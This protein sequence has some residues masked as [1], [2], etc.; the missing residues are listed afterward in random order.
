ML[1]GSNSSF[2]MP[3]TFLLIGIPGLEDGTLW[4]SISFCAIYIVAIVGNCIILYVIKTE[5]S[6]HG[7]M[8]FFLSMLA[9][10]DVVFSSST[11]PQML[12]IFWFDAGRVD[13]VSCLTQMFFVHSIAVVESGILTAMAYDRLIAICFPLRYM[14]ILTNV[15]LGK[16][17][18]AIVGRGIVIIFPIPILVGRLHF[19]T[20]NIV[21]HTYCDHMAVVKVACGD[22]KI[23]YFYGLV[24]SLFITGF[25]LAFIILSY[26]MILRAVHKLPTRGARRKA[27][28]TCGSHVS[29]LTFTYFTAIFSFVTY[30][31]GQ[32]TIPHSVHILVANIYI[33]FPAL[34][35][36][37]IYGLKTKQIRQRVLRSVTHN[38]STLKPQR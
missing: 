6:L 37:L 18:T 33:L 12:S 5:K 30:R 34:L 23:N 26:V 11:V 19:C 28:G 27:L 21:S 3:S 15:L 22:T 13:A 29:V 17:A 20:E 2:S 4:I 14:S 38:I 1:I 35:N 32:N 25:D 8:Y 16:I 31:F 10:N 9:L 24:I 36:S 7:P